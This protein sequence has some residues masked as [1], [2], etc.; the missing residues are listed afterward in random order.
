MINESDKIELMKY[1]PDEN[2]CVAI[3][4]NI[5]FVENH[6]D[7]IDISFPDVDE[8][9]LVYKQLLIMTFSSLESL[10]K[11]V[12]LQILSHCKT[13][14]CNQNCDYK[15]FKTPSEIN[16]AN[17]FSVFMHLQATRLVYFPSKDYV[18]LRELASSRNHVHLFKQI[19]SETP[20]FSRIEIEECLRLFYDT[21]DQLS[22]IYD[23]CFRITDTC[24]K[25]L[26]EN[27]YNDTLSM[28]KREYRDNH[29]FHAYSTCVKLFWDKRLSK[30]DKYY[31]ADLN[32]GKSNYHQ[33]DVELFIGYLGMWLFREG[34]HY[35]TDDAY[36]QA[37]EAFFEKLRKYLPDNEDLITLLKERIKENYSEYCKPIST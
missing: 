26:D 37:M 27:R 13:R 8:K 7:K 25:Q 16:K 5:D 21:L 24:L 32:E 34:I 35:R 11:G 2:L 17:A 30:E 33:F 10:W 12:A 4:R 19:T 28:L 15:K 29:S 31:L 20:S 3:L 22:L 1:I 9:E 6:L 18:L 36:N 14:K 23:Y